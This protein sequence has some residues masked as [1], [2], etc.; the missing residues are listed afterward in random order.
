MQCTIPDWLQ[1]VNCGPYFVIDV[2]S[3]QHQ[4]SI[5]EH[6]MAEM[7]FDDESRQLFRIYMGGDFLG[8]QNTTLSAVVDSME[9]MSWSPRWSTI[10]F[11]IRVLT[12]CVCIITTIINFSV[13]I[14]QR[15]VVVRRHA[16]RVS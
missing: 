9:S 12:V 16:T 15:Q 6:G 13:I 5:G 2:C 8:S 7:E 1:S 10:V 3:L 11:M 4:R 14:V